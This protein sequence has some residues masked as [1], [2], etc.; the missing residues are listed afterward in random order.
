[1]YWIVLISWFSQ[2]SRPKSGQISQAKARPYRLT[3]LLGLD[4]TKTSVGANA[5][6]TPNGELDGFPQHL[7]DFL[8]FYLEMKYKT[9]Q[10]C[11]FI[12]NLS[13][14]GGWTNPSEKYDRQNGFIFPKDRDEHKKCWKPSSRQTILI[15]VNYRDFDRLNC[16]PLCAWNTNC[17]SRTPM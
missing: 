12:N 8:R 11:Q 14:V 17:S 15:W 7:K 1:M 9:N 5:N 3:L 10:N 2:P 16:L 4:T 6:P 13:L